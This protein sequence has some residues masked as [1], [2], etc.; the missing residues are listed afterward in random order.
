MHGSPAAGGDSLLWISN[1]N[2]FRDLKPDAFLDRN[3]SRDRW[4]WSFCEWSEVKNLVIKFLCN[5]SCCCLLCLVFWFI[6]F[7]LQPNPIFVHVG[8][9]IVYVSH[10][11]YSHI[12][13]YSHVEVHYLC[14]FK[15]FIYVHIHTYMFLCS[16]IFHYHGGFWFFSFIYI[17]I[18]LFSNKIEHICTKD[19]I[20][21]LYI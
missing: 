4:T 15:D 20:H 7:I 1:L 18:F 17:L 12:D 16:K 13:T 10:D 5:L 19:K 9:K 3:E 14:T 6:M 2:I 21:M 8:P 11:Q